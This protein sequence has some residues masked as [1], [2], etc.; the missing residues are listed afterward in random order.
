MIPNSYL[1]RVEGVNLARFVFDTRDLNTIRGAGILLLDAAKNRVRE[2]LEATGAKA[3]ME[4]SAGASVGLFAF[5]PPEGI[6]PETIRDAV[7]DSFRNDLQL[8]HSTFV[9][10]IE[11]LNKDFR[12]A[13]EKVLAKNRFRQYQASSIS[14]PETSIRFGVCQLDGVRP[15][16]DRR[17]WAR[18]KDKRQKHRSK[19]VVSRRRYGQRQKQAFYRELTGLSLPLTTKFA[20]EFEEITGPQ[21][22]FPLGNKIAIFYADG[23]RFGKTGSRLGL[24]EKQF[25]AWDRYLRDRR[26]DWLRAFLE[27]ELLPNKNGGWLYQD[28]GKSLYRFET[29]L[30]GGDEVM[31]VMPAWKGWRFAGHFFRAAEQWNARDARFSDHGNENPLTDQDTPLTHTA[32]LI[33]ATIM[34]QS[35]GSKI[36]PRSRW[37]NS[38]K[39]SPAKI[40]RDTRTRLGASATN[41]SIRSWNR[42]T[43]WETIMKDP[44]VGEWGI[45]SNN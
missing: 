28:Q 14:V 30:W 38:A 18:E 2:F 1:L 25:Q 32:A 42:S 15:S 7:A 19:S 8:K 9:V 5:E 17:L 40:L 29:L 37:L 27:D 3:V 10:D 11:V 24:G 6:S 41:S 16:N 20:N 36:W 23:N 21:A 4:I 43:T 22:G 13:S 44:S 45:V 34:R 39:G 35:I 12:A 26:R 33:F 31:F